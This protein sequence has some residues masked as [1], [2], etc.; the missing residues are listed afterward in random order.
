MYADVSVKRQK[1][2]INVLS[3]STNNTRQFFKMCSETLR[4]QESYIRERTEFLEFINFPS[5]VDDR[6]NGQARFRN[7]YAS[8]LGDQFSRK[9]WEQ[10]KQVQEKRDRYFR[11]HLPEVRRKLEKYNADFRDPQWLN[12]NGLARW[13]ENSDRA[14]RMRNT[15]DL[16]IVPLEREIDSASEK[17]LHAL[18]SRNG[19][20]FGGWLDMFSNFYLH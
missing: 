13:Y 14:S 18:A 5:Y 16:F 20:G 19:R 9:L 3:W 4:L 15:M 2:G 8:H 10:M 12:K 11:T 7:D 17:A 1:F 6:R